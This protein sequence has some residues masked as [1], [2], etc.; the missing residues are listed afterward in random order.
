MLLPD[1]IRYYKDAALSDCRG[2]MTWDLLEPPT[3]PSS[4]P[5]LPTPH[6]FEMANSL[7]TY[8][9][10]ADSAEELGLWLDHLVRLTAARS[11]E[12]LSPEPPAEPLAL[13]RVGAEGR[14][15]GGRGLVPQ[16][17]KVL[18]L[19]SSGGAAPPPSRLPQL[20][21]AARGAC[22]NKRSSR[23][24]IAY[25]VDARGAGGDPLG[26]A[27]GGARGERGRRGPLLTLDL[28][29]EFEPLRGVAMDKLGSS[30]LLLHPR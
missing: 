11:V 27:G 23:A 17:R 12:R 13:R 24:A 2:C 26:S 29:E 15:Q 18:P 25:A 19:G 5:G 20:R 1:Q 14:A 30:L 3:S 21:R 4:Y 28:G 16:Q 10:C 7:R 8:V 9:L 22:R 6:S